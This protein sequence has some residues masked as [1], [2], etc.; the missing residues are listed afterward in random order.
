MM[1]LSN[2]LEYEDIITTT[3]EEEE[4][5]ME[6]RLVELSLKQLSFDRREA[7]ECA[8]VRTF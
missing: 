6:S 3:S 5:S 8:E 1:N 2:I 4:I 7:D